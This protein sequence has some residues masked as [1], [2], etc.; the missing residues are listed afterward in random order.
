MVQAEA[1]LV[2]VLQLEQPELV[3]Q[4][5]AVVAEDMYKRLVLHTQEAMAVPGL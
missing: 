2:E 5:V 3:I 1:E 4:A